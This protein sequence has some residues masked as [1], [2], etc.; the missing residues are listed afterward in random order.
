MPESSWEAF[1]EFVVNAEAT[2]VLD[3]DVLELFK[4][5]LS[6]A[7]CWAGKFLDRGDR[8]GVEEV[9]KLGLDQLVKRRH[10]PRTTGR[11]SN[12]RRY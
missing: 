2:A 9:L 10:A 5:R 3:Q 12:T 8:Q 4:R 6:R 11:F 1:A 7:A